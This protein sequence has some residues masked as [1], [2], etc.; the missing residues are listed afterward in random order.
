MIIDK[1]LF[2]FYF[3]HIALYL[4]FSQDASIN[5]CDITSRQ[6]HL[7]RSIAYALEDGDT[8]T[9]KDLQKIMG[10]LSGPSITSLLNALTAK[11]YLMRQAN[12][13]DGR[14]M[15]LMLTEKGHMIVQRM[16][17]SIQAFEAQLK[18]GLLED[19]QQQ[20]LRLLEKVYRNVSKEC[21]DVRLDE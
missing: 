21:T 10:G 1:F 7:L 20:L 15:D 17:A 8:V 5:G 16:D 2:E 11:K 3:R 19:E 9:R 12:T 6:A 18:V 14:Y 13:S 4:N